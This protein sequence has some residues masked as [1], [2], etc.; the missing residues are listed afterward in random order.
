MAPAL[1]AV[2]FVVILVG[3]LGFTNAVERLGKQL[4][5]GEGAVGSLL[6]AVGT[7]MPETLIPIVA[8]SCTSPPPRSVART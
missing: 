4:G 3:A 7:A 1:L 8:A 5:I 2:A 6:A